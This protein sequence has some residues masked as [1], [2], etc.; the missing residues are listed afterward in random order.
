M[1][2]SF[3]K[4]PFLLI[5]GIIISIFVLLYFSWISSPKFSLNAMVPDWV[6]N[7]TDKRENENIRTGV[8]MICLGLITGI[9]LNLKK[10][11]TNWW[12]LSWVLMVLLVFLAEFGQLF[13][14][15]RSFD[16]KDIAWGTLG[17]TIGL[18]AVFVF[19][20]MITKNKLT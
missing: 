17:A 16:F 6:S 7:W 10:A 2:S 12:I 15:L 3:S 8:P 1:N 19:K 4:Y 18:L 11:K 5:C 20:K 14:K 13:I 9:L